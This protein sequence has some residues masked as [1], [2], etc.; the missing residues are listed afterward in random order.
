MKI[1]EVCDIDDSTHLLGIYT[2][3]H[4]DKKIFAQEIKEEYDWRFEDLD[5]EDISH[6]V[7]YRHLEIASNEDEESEVQTVLFFMKLEREDRTP[8]TLYEF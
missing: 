1:L 8:V 2:H 3:G 4:V 6:K 5:I 7:Q